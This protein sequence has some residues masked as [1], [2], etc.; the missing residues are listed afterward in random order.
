MANPVTLPLRALVVTKLAVYVLS[1]W[2]EGADD[3]VFLRSLAPHTDFADHASI[4]RVTSTTF[5]KVGVAHLNAVTRVLRH[6]AASR[7]L[8]AG[9]AL[10]NYCRGVRTHQ[11]RIHQR[12]SQYGSPGAVGLRPISSS[13]SPVMSDYG[14][15]SAFATQLERF[16]EFKHAMGF[17]GKSRIWYL[18]K[19][20]CLLHQTS[21]ESL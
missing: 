16:L 12:V 7:L 17:Y 10:P 1:K 2:P 13:R 6:N 14:F 11:R 20:R 4:H 21:P 18:K 19:I 5:R 9:V 15:T 8:Q 3:R